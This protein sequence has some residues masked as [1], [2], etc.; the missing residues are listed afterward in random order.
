[1]YRVITL[2]HLLANIPGGPDWEVSGWDSTRR[3]T[4]PEALDALLGQLA[5][6][7]L[8]GD[9]GKTDYV[10]ANTNFDI[11]GDVVAH[12]TG[13]SFEDYV[14]S[15][16][17]DPLG[18]THSS[19]LLAKIDPANLSAVH[20]MDDSGKVVTNLVPPEYDQVHTPSAGLLSDVDEMSLWML[21]NL[22][23][24]ELD[25]HR[26]LSPTSYDAMWT[27]QTPA[28]W[29]IGGIFQEWGL[30]WELATVGGHRFAWWGGLMMGG[31]SAMVLAPDDGVGVFVIANASPSASYDT[32]WYAV[33]L[34]PVLI[35]ELLGIS[36]PAE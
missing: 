27:A 15:E 29:G 4:S 34:A 20:W 33:D 23:R 31:T 5:T 35:Y 12:V 6:Y 19:F 21:V 22:Q 16:I 3:T 8:L 7:P 18:M 30:G 14:Q 10:Y 24:G 28:D 25:G 9:P 13:R 26:I 2:R 32:P 17:L 1:R 36:A 11:L